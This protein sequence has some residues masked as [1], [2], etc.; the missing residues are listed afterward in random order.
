MSSEYINM[1]D[2]FLGHCGVTY[3]EKMLVS[4]PYPSSRKIILYNILVQCTY[5]YIYMY[6]FIHTSIY[7]SVVVVLGFSVSDSRRIHS[8]YCN[9]QGTSSSDFWT[10]IKS[11]HLAQISHSKIQFLM[12]FI[13]HIINPI[14]TNFVTLG[15]K[16][17]TNQGWTRF[18]S[19]ASLKQHG[20]DTKT[21][22]KLN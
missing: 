17:A 9:L 1:I 22:T 19:P 3:L 7:W 6:T 4:D 16:H 14:D 8:I 2:L 15:P 12:T 18:W 11:Q 13:L 20:C 10:A 21:K 5:I